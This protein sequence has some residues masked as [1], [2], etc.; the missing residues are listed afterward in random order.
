MADQTITEDELAEALETIRHPEPHDGCGSCRAE[1]GKIFARVAE[2]RE[3]EYEP[4]QLYQSAAGVPY[5]RLDGLARPWLRIWPTGDV[6]AYD[7]AAPLRPLRK[8]VSEGSQAAK[9]RHGDLRDLLKARTKVPHSA[10][11]DL[12]WDIIKL[13]EAT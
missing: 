3:P 12:A 1:A 4:G 2:H 8:L 5:L 10:A 13:L 6:Q 9:L 11:V 7:E